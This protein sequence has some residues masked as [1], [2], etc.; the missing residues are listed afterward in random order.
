MTGDL[1]LAPVTCRYHKLAT[2]AAQ[3]VDCLGEKT[4]S[5]LVKP[6]NFKHL[7]SITYLQSIARLQ[8]LASGCANKVPHASILLKR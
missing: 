2:L 7:P 8:P 1:E 6:L 5:A 3:P 4:I